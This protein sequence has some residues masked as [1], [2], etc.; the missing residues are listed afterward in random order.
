MKHYLLILVLEKNTAM[1]K[2]VATSSAVY[3]NTRFP[4]YS[5]SKR[6]ANSN[7]S[8]YTGKYIVRPKSM[9]ADAHHGRIR[10]PMNTK[11][12]MIIRASGVFMD[13]SIPCVYL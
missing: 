4:E 11:I 8:K 3:G 2:I 5:V 9:I 10:I 13:S 6:K 7:A 1:R 12:P